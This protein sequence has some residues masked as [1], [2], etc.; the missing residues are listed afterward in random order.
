VIAVISH[1][2]KDRA[3][4]TV[5][6][7]HGRPRD[8]CSAGLSRLELVPLTFTP[9]REH[10]EFIFL[11]VPATGGRLRCCVRHTFCPMLART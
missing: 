8:G 11:S 10:P 5:C 2:E 9:V 4:A 3:A 6:H 1:A 7:R